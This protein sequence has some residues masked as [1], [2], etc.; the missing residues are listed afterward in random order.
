MTAE[1]RQFQQTVKLSSTGVFSMMHTP[2][3]GPFPWE[4]HVTNTAPHSVTF[5]GSYV[6]FL[7]D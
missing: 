6:G 7:C 4:A 3:N 1:L 2:E 5:L